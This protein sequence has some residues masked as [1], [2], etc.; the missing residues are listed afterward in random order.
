MAFP[1]DRSFTGTLRSAERT[2][3]YERHKPIAV[4]MI[5]VVFLLPLVGVYVSGLFG[6]VS[7]VIAS[8]GGYYLTPYVV[9]R[10]GGKADR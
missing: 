2:A 10:L 5:L 1:S 9:L 4:V 7:G 6:A 8:V 3:F